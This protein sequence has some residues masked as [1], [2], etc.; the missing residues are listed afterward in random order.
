MVTALIILKLATDTQ[1]V[2]VVVVMFV[3]KNSFSDP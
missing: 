1:A 3:K 2:N